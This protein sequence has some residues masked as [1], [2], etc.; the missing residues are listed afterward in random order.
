MGDR[1]LS[2][3]LDTVWWIDPIDLAYLEGSADTENAVVGLFSGKALESDL[4]GVVLLGD[5]VIEPILSVFREVAG[6][7]AGSRDRSH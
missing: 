6:W 1:A 2:T 7:Q 5:Q 3:M 4:N